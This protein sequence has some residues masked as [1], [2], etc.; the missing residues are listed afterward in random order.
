VDGLSV[1]DHTFVVTFVD[2]TGNTATDTVVVT[3]SSDLIPLFIA[4]GAGVAIVV[5]IIVIYL[6][7]KKGAG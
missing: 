3:V 5:V 6:G 1:G 7:R 2:G 4:A